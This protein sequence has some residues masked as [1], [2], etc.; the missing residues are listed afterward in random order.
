MQYCNC[1]NV[2]N[3]TC[4]ASVF[5]SYY[6]NNYG[7]EHTFR[8]SEWVPWWVVPV[9]QRR[10]SSS[11]P[12]RAKISVVSY[13]INWVMILCTQSGTFCTQS[14]TRVFAWLGIVCHE[15]TPQSPYIPIPK[16]AYMYV[17]TCLLL[18]LI[19]TIWLP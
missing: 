12:R 19:Q 15:S 3:Y 17:A 9:E 6:K 10:R 7:I 2:I 14:A 8:V 11:F 1:N 4:L 13:A 18:K 16:Y 5:F